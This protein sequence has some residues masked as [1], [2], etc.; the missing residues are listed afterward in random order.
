MKEKTVTQ[1]H[2]LRFSLEGGYLECFCK[3]AVRDNTHS[4]AP[5]STVT[6]TICDPLTCL[7]E[8]HQ[9][10]QKTLKIPQR[11]ISEVLLIALKLQ[12][13]KFET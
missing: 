13:F 5:P 12:C 10:A 1:G 9:N 8:C 2:H 11:E 4:Q 7:S 3:S 6:S